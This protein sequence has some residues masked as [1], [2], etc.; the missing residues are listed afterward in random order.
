[1]NKVNLLWAILLACLTNYS[2]AQ[3]PSV[4]E[5]IITNVTE[6][7]GTCS[8]DVE[9]NYATNGEN[10]SSVTV[11]VSICGGADLLTTSCFGSLKNAD[12]PYTSLISDPALQAPCSADICVTYSGHSNAGCGNGGSNNCTPAFNEVAVL[13]SLP[14]DLVS[15]SGHADRYNKIKLEWVTAS[16]EQNDYFLIE[17]SFD[18]T[19]FEPIGRIE[20]NGNTNAVSYYSY[21]DQF[22]LKGENYYRLRQI[23]TDGQY[24]Y[25]SVVL[26]KMEMDIS[27]PVVIAKSVSKGRPTIIFNELPKANALIEV[28]NTSGVNVLNTRLT[29]GTNTLELDLSENN[30][31]MYFV[32]VPVGKEFVVKKFIILAD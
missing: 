29:E 26:V 24:E 2:Y 21:M 27:S 25:S 17:R 10:N 23:D 11:T 7:S 30:P 9:I 6:S 5:A 12:S 15:F 14:V 16:E 28:F 8:F 22:P 18:G 1:M 4:N 13:G 31:G 3:C 19:N 32:R 20:G